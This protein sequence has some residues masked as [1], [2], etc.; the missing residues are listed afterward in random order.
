MFTAILL[1]NVFEISQKM[2]IRNK[3]FRS[4]FDLFRSFLK[5]VNAIINEG[6]QRDCG[7]RKKMNGEVE[8][9]KSR[10]VEKSKCRKV[11]MSKSEM[12]IYYCLTY[13]V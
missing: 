2:K 6:L 11:E 10:K 13:F 3:Y 12:K 8:K 5:E 7:S 1:K 4:F 9:S